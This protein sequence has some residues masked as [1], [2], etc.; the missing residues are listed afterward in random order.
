LKTSSVC[1]FTL[2]M[3]LA[4]TAF[5][6]EV[7]SSGLT[8]G[9]T[10]QAAGQQPIE[11][12]QITGSRITRSGFNTPTPVTAVTSDELQAMAPGQL[13][14]SLSEL[15]Q[16]LG[17]QT[18][19]TIGFPSSGGTNLNLRG[20]GI[21]RTLVLLDGR[22]MVS[23]NRYGTV[24]VGSLPSALVRSVETVT[25][26]ASATYGSDAVAGV[27]NFI[28]DTNYTGIKAHVEGGETQYGDGKNWEA[29]LAG[30][31]DVGE[32]GHLLFSAEMF[33]QDK[34]DTF[35]SQR[36]RDYL[37]QYG[38]VTN[39]DPNGPDQ[40]I[41]PYSEPTN[42]S[43]AGVLMFPKGPK[44][45]IIVP[46]YEFLSNGEAVPQYFSGVGN[47]Y[48]GCQCQ[49]LD[50]QTYGV[51]SDN[52]IAPGIKSAS[53][54]AYFDYDLTDNIN[55]Y[56]QGL[57]G[58]SSTN[59]RPSGITLLTTWSPQIY[60]EN[61]YLPQNIKDIM[62]DHGWDTVTLGLLGLQDPNSPIGDDRTI[63]SNDTYSG[64][65]GFKANVS[66][67]KFMDGWHINGYYQHGESDQ[68]QHF[69]NGT[70]V[71]KLPLAL[72]VVTDPA[73]GSPVCYAALVNPQQFGDCVPLDIFGGVQ[74]IS[75]EAAAY[76]TDKDKHNLS[77][78]K[79]DVAELNFDGELWKGIG[80]GPVSMAFGVSYRKEHFDQ[81]VQ[82]PDD[83]FVIINGVN[84]GYRGLVPDQMPG[85]P[86]SSW[87]AGVRR[88]AVPV[89]YT[90]DNSSSTVQ[91]TSLRSFGGGFNVKEA[92]TEFDIPLIA[93]TAFAQSLNL[94][95]AARYADYSGSGGIWAYKAG[96]DWQV[97]SD[98]RFR[99]TYSRDVRAATLE[100]RFD[101][102]R[103]GA[104]VRDPE[105]NNDT[106]STA[107]FTGGNENLDPEKA[108]TFTVGTVFQPSFLP[109]FQA[110][111]D[112]YSINVK[113]AIGQLTSQNV[114]DG[115]FDSG[116]TGSL[117]QYVHRDAD[118][119]ISR[120]D[121]LFINLSKQKI[122]GI[123]LE[124]QY[125]TDLTLVGGGAESLNWRFYGSWLDENSRTTPGTPKD[126]QAGSGNFPH[127]KFT[128]NINY[129]N[130]PVGIFVQERWIGGVKLDRTYVESDHHIDGVKTIEDN[131][132]PSVWYT[133][134]R[135]NYTIGADSGHTWQIYGNITN[136]F[137]K[138]PPVVAGTIGRGGTNQTS[139]LHDE[140]GRRFLAG[141]R[142]TY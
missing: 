37:K 131:H 89:G 105:K 54:F 116:G 28:L 13:V 115:C 16:F 77:V 29:S 87:L 23:G 109:G 66:S 26:G 10:A 58:N 120:V 33:R 62:A 108:D 45:S 117:C 51:D 73:T 46:N 103:G 57:Y 39:P 125:R 72:D 112:W 71:D 88:G 48:A 132:I 83:E 91:F 114:V 34:I 99:G 137:N 56:V 70:R 44:N 142:F 65:I 27:V 79:Q 121:N 1:A 31:T 110:S 20:A 111:L 92:F 130:G 64:T 82:D 53:A 100:E 61:P 76:I 98:I 32:R 69:V 84:T 80:A 95:L 134:L 127:W 122:S 129:S 36:K 75:K 141:V 9:Q 59:Q 40:I 90:G 63:Q 42:F 67:A 6:G 52:A 119:F 15:P 118:G 35:N 17:N 30:G 107:A 7:S 24:D 18:P 139:S 68:D 124:T 133:D 123:D 102:T 136:L 140:I 96:I 3:G 138:T 21:N 113:A 78:V 41:R 4:G 22:R 74:N 86:E 14:E 126:D 94:S 49:A 106:F 12:I 19:Q 25:G 8:A 81:H 101:Q 60:A 55:V 135:L 50:T 11:E 38:R 104:T 128:T 93:N 43:N 5:A 97:I 2:T 47:Q 85:Y